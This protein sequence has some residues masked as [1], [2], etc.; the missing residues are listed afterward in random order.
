MAKDKEKKKPQQDGESK[1]SKKGKKGGDE[2]VVPRLP[3]GYVPRLQ[4]K[5][6]EEIAPALRQKFGYSTPMAVPRLQKIVIN[7][8]VGDAS[9]DAK[10]LDAA[11]AELGQ[12]A[13]Q[14]PKLTRARRAVAQFKI[15]DGMPIGCCVTLRG[16]R[17]YD[18]LDRLINVAIPRVRDFRG[19][20][21]NSF[22]GRGNYSMG[23]REHLIFTE[24]DYSKVS[25]VRGMDI[26]AVTSAKSDAECRE[27]LTLFGVPFRRN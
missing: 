27:L 1:K 17:M 8:G 18:F 7:M 2:P 11:M 12:I 3:E 10:V 23:V 15:R 21:T 14:K 13:G 16:R 5:Y 20:P 19:L 25:K 24:I 26:T 4:T 9:A 22:D 6:R